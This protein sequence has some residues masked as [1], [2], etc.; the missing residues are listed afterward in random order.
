MNEKWT[1]NLVGR[2]HNERVTFQEIAEELGVTKSYVSMILNGARKPKGIK[3]RME[4]AFSDIVAR[5]KEVSG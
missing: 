2:M 5:R 4:T 1:G 3:E